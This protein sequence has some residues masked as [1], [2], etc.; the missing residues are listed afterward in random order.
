MKLITE[1]CSDGVI[2]AR[3]VNGGTHEL[4]GYR[5]CFSLL[6][7]C[8]VVSGCKILLQFGGYV[9]MAPDN[10]RILKIGGE[11]NFSFKYDF[12]AELSHPALGIN[13]DPANMVL[14]GKGDPVYALETLKPWVKHVH[15]KDARKSSAGH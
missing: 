10:Q 6:S 11:W 12:L 3:F 13:F 4:S 5:I 1:T 9:E 8:S 14:Y 15:I 7:K 2:S